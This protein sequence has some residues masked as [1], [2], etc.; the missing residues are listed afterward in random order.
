MNIND[1]DLAIFLYF[2]EC[3]QETFTV[4]D[5][6]KELFKPEDR[7][8]LIKKVSMINYRLRKWVKQGLFSVNVEHGVK[9]YSLNMQNIHYGDSSLTINNDSIETGKAIALQM[10][11]NDYLIVCF[12]QKSDV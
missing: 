12:L 2:L 1:V 4:V 10:K 7:E 11:D 8:C 9:Y 5:I 6:A 3:E